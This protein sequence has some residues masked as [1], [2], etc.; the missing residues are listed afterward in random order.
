MKTILTIALTLILGISNAQEN[1]EKAMSKGMD[2][3]M[4]AK[5]SQELLTASQL[6]QR[7]SESATD[8]WEA[9]YWSAYSM[10]FAGMKSEKEELQDLN[11]DNALKLLENIE[12]KNPDLSEVY[13]LRAYL[14][15]MKISVSPMKRAVSQTPIAM[16]L[17]EKA[18][19][20][21]PNNPRPYYV[22]GQHIFYTPGFF[23]G[24]KDNAKPLL[25]KAI[26]N[27]SKEEKSENFKPRWGKARASQLLELCK[28]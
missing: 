25:E 17:I 24:G 3:L 1:Y 9:Q 7:V 22:Q 21:N 12:D 14:M 28:K 19:K 2:L 15:L 11:Y 5:S 27:Y 20:V 13:T 18:K 8:K 26:E 4:N 23:G 16:E 6:F 10:L